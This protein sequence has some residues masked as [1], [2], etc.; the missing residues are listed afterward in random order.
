MSEVA[1][2]ASQNNLHNLHKLKMAAGQYPYLFHV[3][4]FLKIVHVRCP[5]RVF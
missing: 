3:E 2:L 1:A 4:T 5:F